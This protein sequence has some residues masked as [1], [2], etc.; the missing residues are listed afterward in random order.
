MN[1]RRQGFVVIGTIIMAAGLVAG[2]CAGPAKPGES[3]TQVRLNPTPELQGVS[4]SQDDIDNRVTFTMDEGFRAMT[5]DFAR[6]IIY[7]DRPSRL[8]PYPR[9][10]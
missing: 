4:T 8:D 7:V 9:I 1:Q 5:T 6:T 10:R 2:G 3:T